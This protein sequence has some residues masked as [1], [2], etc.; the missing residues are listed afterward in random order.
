MKRALLFITVLAMTI[1]LRAQVIENIDKG[2]TAM[3][4]SI[5]PAAPASLAKAGTGIA[6]MSS[7]EWASSGNVASLPYSE[8]RM[9]AGFSFLSF[10]PGNQ[11]GLNF[12]YSMRAGNRICLSAGFSRYKG[13][14]Y[15]V[16][17]ATGDHLGHFTPTDMKMNIAVAYSIGERLSAGAALH[18]MGSSLDSE[19]KLNAVSADILSFYNSGDLHLAA[20]LKNLGPAVKSSAG[21]KYNLPSSLALATEYSMALGTVS[22]LEA[23]LDCEYFFQAGFTGS[24]SVDYSAWDHV[25]ARLGAHIGNELLPT[26]AAC[27]VGIEFAGAALDIAYLFASE[28][29]GGSFMAGLSYRF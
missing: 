2:A 15:E 19:T 27:G 29:L 3:G 4:F 9:A 18:Y 5:I 20:G 13:D 11:K 26:Y 28:T 25:H 12:G 23:D 22:V 7:P 8:S 17:G 16:V 24:A 1:Q 14:A 10:S 21:E 6:S